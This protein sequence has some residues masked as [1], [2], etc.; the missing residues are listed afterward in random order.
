MIPIPIIR[1]QY[2]E[3]FAQ[4]CPIIKKYLVD[5]DLLLVILLDPFSSKVPADVRESWSSKD[6]A[7]AL[8]RNY[9]YDIH[10]KREKMLENI[11][12]S[13]QNIELDIEDEN[14][15]IITLYESGQ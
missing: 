9:F 1:S 2:L 15:I 6:E 7:Y 3:K 4:S 10:K 5:K 13:H 14:E 12:Q 8:S 11:A